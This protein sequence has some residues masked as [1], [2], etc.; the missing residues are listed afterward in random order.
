MQ[1]WSLLKANQ[2]ISKSKSKN[3]PE[4]SRWTSAP[5][6]A[7]VWKTALWCSCPEIAEQ[8]LNH[9]TNIHTI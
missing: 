2:A 9:K 3:A 6:A 8:P 5:D 7:L 4:A 1:I